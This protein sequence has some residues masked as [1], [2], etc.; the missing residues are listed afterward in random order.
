MKQADTD[1][2]I[3]EKTYFIGFIN[4]SNISLALIQTIMDP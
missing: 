4:A 3:W 1:L 2:M